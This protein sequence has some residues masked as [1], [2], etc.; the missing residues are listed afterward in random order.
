[1]ARLKSMG[2]DKFRVTCA[3]AFCLHSAFVSFDLAGVEDQA[4]F[5]SIIERR[6]FVCTRCGGRFVSSGL[7]GD[8][9]SLSA[10]AFPRLRRAGGLA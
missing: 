1:M 5:P 10:C 8:K 6:R 4:P 3:Q 7:T 2:A 9:R